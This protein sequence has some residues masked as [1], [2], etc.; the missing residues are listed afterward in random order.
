MWPTLTSHDMAACIGYGENTVAQSPTACMHASCGPQEP[1]TWP[2]RSMTPTA[3][4]SAQEGPSPPT[5]LRN[6]WWV[7]PPAAYAWTEAG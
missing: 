1:A 5:W 7:P 6:V 2:Y 3:S 4:S